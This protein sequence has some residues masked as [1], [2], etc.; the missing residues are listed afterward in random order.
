MEE[1]K[2]FKYIVGIFDVITKEIRRNIKK[3][4]QNLDV[5]LGVGVYTDEFCENTLFTHPAKTLEHRMQ[6]AK[7]MGGVV[8]TFPVSSL[9]KEETEIAAQEAYERYLAEIKQLNDIKKYKTGFIIGSFDL[10]H[11]GH[12]EN[13]NIASEV[14]NDLYVVVKT[15]ERIMANKHKTPVQNTTERANNL[16]M[17]RQVRDVLYMDLDSTRQ[18]IIEDIIAQY[19]ID[20]DGAKIEPGEIAAIFG[21]DL[22]DKEM[23]HES[24][25]GDVNLVFTPRSSEKMQTISSSA[26]Q[27][28]VR[29]NGGLAEYQRREDE[30]L[31][32][33]SEG[34][35]K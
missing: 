30:N 16:R 31:R 12:M 22:K 8:F 5:P 24:E 13:I 4:G 25:W 23:E 27:Q 6:I 28:I 26:Y 3:D 11:A 20:H 34:E 33:S 14:C 35:Q 10:L 18:D 15:D 9:S 1:E 19:E 29:S 32:R 2:N 21:E 17:L 7:G